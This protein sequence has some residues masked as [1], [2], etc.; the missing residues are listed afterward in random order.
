MTAAATVQVSHTDFGFPADLLTAVLAWGDGR[1]DAAVA[2]MHP[3]LFE[4]ADEDLAAAQRRAADHLQSQLPQSPCRVLKTGPVSEL[5][6]SGVA[7]LQPSKAAWDW[8]VLHDAVNRLRPLDLFEA[9]DRLMVPADAQMLLLDEFSLVRDSAHPFGPHRWDTF[10]QLARR[11]GWRVVFEQDLSAAAAPSFKAVADLLQHHAARL[12]RQLGLDD[13]ALLARIDAARQAHRAHL[14]G[15]RC[16]RLLR[17]QRPALPALRLRAVQPQDGD[18]V[19]AMFPDRFGHELSAAE[20][21]WKYAEGRGRA[22]G[23][24][25]GDRLV[26][27]CGGLNRPALLMGEPGMT[28]QIGDVMVMPHA[29][30]GLG[31]TNALHQVTATFIE[32]HVG[33][34]ER[35][36][37]GFGFPNSRHMKLAERL[38]L[39]APV[40]DVQQLSWTALSAIE[41]ADIDGDQIEPADAALLREDTPTWHALTALWKKMAAACTGSALGIRDP[42]WLRHRYGR[43]PGCDYVL[44]R[45]STSEGQLFGL[46]VLRLLPHAVELIDL[47]GDPRHF[48]RLVRHARRAAADWGRDRLE[49]WITA[50]HAAWVDDPADPAVVQQINVAV[51]A[52]IHSQGYP[53][54]RLQGRWFLMGGDTDFH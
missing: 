34:G 24:F 28:C 43:R 31:R 46:F 16:Y 40:D 18:A 29:I 8:W 53:A 3:G 21:R 1:G 35:Y 15:R 2:S 5:L 6:R 45:V 12:Q 26:A 10:L 14:E 47:V 36:V 50:S 19:R 38:G 39:Y 49:V 22:V 23:L 27:H 11:F 9:A 52:N 41:G 37:G 30:A 7:H 42:A 54:A 32:A 51:P 44:H 48:Q 13:A 17:L 33:W 20:W 4:H 25:Q